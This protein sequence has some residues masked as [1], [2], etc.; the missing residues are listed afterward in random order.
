MAES[1]DIASLIVLKLVND[2]EVC[3]ALEA[4]YGAPVFLESSSG[5]KAI[6]LSALL[7]L[8]TKFAPLI[9]LILSL[10]MGGGFSP[11]VIAALI[12]ALAEAFGVPV[13]KIQ[14]ALATPTP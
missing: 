7:A 6:D 8:F 5:A 9:P 11:T 10:F 13:A 2:P 12:T 14:A 3:A 4:K 1:T